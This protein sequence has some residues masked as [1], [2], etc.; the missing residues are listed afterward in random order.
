L[1]VEKD[2]VRGVFL[3]ERE[4]LDAVLALADDSMA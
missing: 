3:D 1:Y 4:R 2:E